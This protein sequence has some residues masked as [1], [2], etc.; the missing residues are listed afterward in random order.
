MTNLTR[1]EYLAACALQGMLAG[2]YARGTDLVDPDTLAQKAMDY[3]LPMAA[4]FARHDAAADAKFEQHVVACKQ[5]TE[6]DG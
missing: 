5:Q 1:I 2:I 3:A 6:T 4:Q